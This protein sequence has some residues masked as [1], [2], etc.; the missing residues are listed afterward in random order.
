MAIARAS[1][2]ERPKDADH[3]YPGWKER[4][5]HTAESSMQAATFDWKKKAGWGRGP[6]A[7]FSPGSA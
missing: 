4:L 6:A 3:I 5:G 7:S 2:E 1:S